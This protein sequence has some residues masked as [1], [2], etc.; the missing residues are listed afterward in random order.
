MKRLL[1]SSLT[2]FILG[3]INLKAQKTL[4]AGW[5]FD[6]T[7]ASPNTPRAVAANLGVYSANSNLYSD[8]TNGSSSWTQSSELNAFGGSVISDPRSTTAAGLTYSIISN[9]ANSKAL[10]FVT[11][12]LSYTKIKIVLDV[13]GTSTGFSTG[14][15]AYSTNGTTWTDFGTNTATTSTTFSQKSLDLTSIT[16]V[17]NQ[18]IVYF[19]YT[20]SG[21]TNTSGNNRID[22]VMITSDDGTWFG[23]STTD[24]GTQANW[25]PA[26]F[27][28]TY[29]NVPNTFVYNAIITASSNNPVL[30][31]AYFINNMYVLP[32]ASITALTG[33]SLTINGTMTLRS[34]AT[35][36]ASI[37]NSAGT[38]SGTVTQERYIPLKSSRAWSLI[39]S[40][41]SQSLSAGWQQQI[42]ITGANA[43]T[44]ACTVDGT[45]GFDVTT[46]NA[47][48][49]Y[50]YDA[51][52]TAGSRWVVVPNTL[53]TNTAAGK[54]FRLNIRGPRSAGCA[55]LDGSSLAPAA[56]TLSSTGIISNAQKNLGSFTIDYPNTGTNS[57]VFIGNPYPSQISFSTLVA[58]N[59]NIGNNYAIYAPGNTAGNYAYW[60]PIGGTYTGGNTGLNDATGNI[61]ASGQAIFV[62]AQP[63][64]TLTLNFN[65][66]QKTASTQNGYFRTR[67]FNEMIRV[68]YMLD[69]SNKADEIIVRYANDNDV[70]NTKVGSMDIVS[71]NTG[72]QY[73]NSLKGNNLMAVQT[74]S[75]QTLTT[76]TVALNVKSNQSGTYKLNFSDYD[77]FKATGIYLIDKYTNTIHNVK[78]SS[79]YSFTVDKNNAATQTNRFALVFSKAIVPTVITGIKVY[80]NPADKQITVQLPATEGKYTVSITD[81][82]GKRVYQSQLAAGT[83]TINIAKLMK[84]NYVLELT[85]AKGNR[86]VEKIVKL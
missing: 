1:L 70:S 9:S 7:A 28:S 58:D 66:A 62:R 25:I 56:V 42:H 30:G 72:T 3:I 34:S 76:D 69:D 46:T 77:N 20:V 31:A 74:R 19:R 45:T 83:Q 52:L 5:T 21:A 51:S 15:W 84:G 38:F 79:T 47:P 55:L 63:L 33:T 8:G 44:T 41:V 78:S 49:A 67:S 85:D 75:L 14:Q 22:N 43:G 60:D 81:V 16:A 50:T 59:I 13:R 12:T 53:S 80:P 4:L 86:S 54:G 10:V 37:G 61:I 48:S 65:E 35:G 27:N 24:Y 11:S 68:A 2:I 17:E 29:S 23:T 32:G 18:A 57:Y 39:S 26:G 40:P 73:L 36:T 82:A 6:A 71:M 64:S